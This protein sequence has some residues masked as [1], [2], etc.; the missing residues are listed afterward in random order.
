MIIACILL[1]PHIEKYI[2][3]IYDG[4][5]DSQIQVTEDYSRNS[6]DSDENEQRMESVTEEIPEVEELEEWKAAEGSTYVEEEGPGLI[7]SFNL[8][9]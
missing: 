2:S 6:A 8:Y 4:F 7:E 1:F 9:D 5:A 3:G